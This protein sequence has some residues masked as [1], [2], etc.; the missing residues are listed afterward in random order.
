[1]PAR[2]PKVQCG[3][4]PLTLVASPSVA[5]LAFTSTWRVRVQ[6]GVK[7]SY[8]VALA[9]YPVHPPGF[10]SGCRWDSDSKSERVSDGTRRGRASRRVLGHKGSVLGHE[11][12]MNPSVT[13]KWTIQDECDGLDSSLSRLALRPKNEDH[14]QWYCPRTCEDAEGC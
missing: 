7:A 1:M 2:I 13:I 10:V 9:R 6:A 12:S 5:C 4:L 3:M 14:C 8:S 11:I